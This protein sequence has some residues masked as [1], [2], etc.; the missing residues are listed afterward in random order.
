MFI[1]GVCFSTFPRHLLFQSLPDVLAWLG[2][3]CLQEL[4]RD[5]SLAP[6]ACPEEPRQ[7]RSWILSLGFLLIRPFD[8]PTSSA[9]PRICRVHFLRLG[10][11]DPATSPS[12]LW[13]ELSFQDHPLSPASPL[14]SAACSWGRRCLLAVD[15]AAYPSFLGDVHGQGSWFSLIKRILN[16]QI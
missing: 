12:P 1:L 13:H 16:F 4:L 5:Q 2:H 7:E 6:G 3:P 14:V 11:L 10:G 9:V 8:S 15:M